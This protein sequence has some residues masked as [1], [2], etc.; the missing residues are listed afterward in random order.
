[1]KARANTRSGTRL[2]WLNRTHD[3]SSIAAA[4]KKQQDF[5]VGSLNTQTKLNYTINVTLSHLRSKEFQRIH[6]PCKPQH[7]ETP[8]V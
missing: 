8:K 6:L 7:R 5:S 3:M 1:M 4:T 2:Q